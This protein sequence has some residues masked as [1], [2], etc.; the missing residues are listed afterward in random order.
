[1]AEVQGAGWD[2][3]VAET[4]VERGVSV[5]VVGLKGKVG[6][7]ADTYGGSGGPDTVKHVG[8]EGDGDEE[9]FRVADAHYVARFVLRE[10]V[11]A[12]VHAGGFYPRSD[13]FHYIQMLKMVSHA[14]TP[15]SKKLC[16]LHPLVRL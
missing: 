13:S 9:V 10:P 15:Y 3:G 16:L 12:G 6:E 1:M 14:R 8:S 4:L 7:R 11:C 5:S 2:Y